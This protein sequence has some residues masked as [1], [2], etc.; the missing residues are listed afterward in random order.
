MSIKDQKIQ[1]PTGYEGLYQGAS[2]KRKIADALMEQ[3]L[4]GS[5]NPVSYLQVLADMAK[6]WAGKRLG[7]KADNLETDAN[8]KVSEDWN[9][10]NVEFNNDAAM[11]T[12]EMMVAKWSKDPMMGDR[13]KPYQDTMTAGM[14]QDQEYTDRGGQW[15]R[16]GDVG[17][18]TYDP[19]KPT[20]KV[21]R[22]PNGRIEIN[23]V[24]VAAER[25]SGG[26]D[27]TGLP[28]SMS[29][30]GASQ[31]APQQAMPQQ[32]Q[33]T[34]VTFEQ[35]QAAIQ[36]LGPERA[37]SWATGKGIAIQIQSEA[38]ALQLP[39]GTKIILPDGSPGVIP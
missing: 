2:R 11:Y 21:L 14:K 26:F 24:A 27:T 8:M 13:V 3:G 39:S 20:D 38:Q 30:P 16:K 18:G 15:L 4:Q 19:G 35:A 31:A 5:P 37:A 25:S 23:P 34:V 36:A 9:A 17:I 29:W 6:V 28:Q 22:M 32:Q 1:I 7:K 12:P 33:P 10:K